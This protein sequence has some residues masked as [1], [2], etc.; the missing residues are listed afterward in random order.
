MSH[1]SRNT[2]SKPSHE[3]GTMRSYVIGFVLSL[4]FTFIPYYLVVNRTISGNLLLAT[5]IG[6]AVLQMII[7]ITFFLHL[8]RGPKPN[9]NLFFFIG[10]VGIILIV[11]GG[12]IMI[13]NNLNYNML[14]HDQTKKLTNDEGIYQI[15]GE[16]TGACQGQHDNHKVTI[17]NSQVSPLQTLASKCD[18]LTFINEDDE[19]REITFGT[20]PDHGSYA[21]EDELIVRKGRSKS[22]TLS[23][24]GSYQFHDHIKAE[25]A[26]FFTVTP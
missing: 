3:H 11:V 24:A 19:A 21:G 26:G 20:H 4:V 10:T 6:I 25:I 2:I 17:K 5:I 9:W 1:P 22:I 7:Q 16:K 14:P 8:G 13:I 15:G 18:T 23:E 12:S